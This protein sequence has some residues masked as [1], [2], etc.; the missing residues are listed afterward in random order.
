MSLSSNFP[1]IRPTLL[2]D[3]ANVG[4]LDPRVTFTRATTATYF[5]YAGVLQTAASG[6]AR[7][8]Y[9]PSTLAALGLL[10]E[11]Q[12]TNL[13]VSSNDFR[14]AGEGN[15]VSGWTEG[16]VVAEQNVSAN[17][18]GPDGVA[19]SASTITWIAPSAGNTRYQ[20]VAKTAGVT[21][22]CSVFLKAG[23]TQYTSLQNFLS[24]VAN[25]D[26]YIV[27]D[28]NALTVT[29]Q[30]GDAANMTGSI[31]AVGG[32]W[33][34]VT[35]THVDTQS[36]TNVRWSIAP[37][38]SNGTT[39]IAGTVILYGAEIEVGAFVTS[40]IPTT[41]TALTRNAD[42]AS[43]TGANFS[44]WFNAS[45]GSLLTQ[46][47]IP[48]QSAAT[49]IA[50]IGDSTASER[51]IIT[52]QTSRAGTGLRV[53]DGG[54]DQCDINLTASFSAGQSMRTIG[55]YAANDFAVCQNGGSVGTDTS[56]T[57]PTVTALYIGQNGVSAATNSHIQRIAYY[58]TRLPNATLQALT[59]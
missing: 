9:N 35:A 13:L 22:T 2:L 51:I 45:A 8:D 24:G 36:N 16:A 21:V 29:A 7:F 52:T 12:R 14:T 57:L 20:G 31:T 44:S 41:T 50:T 30:G 17:V 48:A 5:D 23:S 59:S 18:V 3:F 42:V 47:S 54:V 40:Y 34:R 6:V 28:W 49:S 11:E 10:I 26:G 32:G 4:R 58:P 15:P 46:F 37:T 56:G 55:A 33:Y 19:N 27:V 1:T 39:V 25:R 43:M 38:Q 53:V